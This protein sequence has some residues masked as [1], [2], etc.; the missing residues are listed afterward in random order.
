[1]AIVLQPES[2]YVDQYSA[3]QFPQLD[4]YRGVQTAL[5]KYS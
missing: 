1:M 3:Q 5:V 4:A 2:I